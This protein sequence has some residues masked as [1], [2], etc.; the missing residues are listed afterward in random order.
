MKMWWDSDVNMVKVCWRSKC[1]GVK[2]VVQT[3]AGGSMEGSVVMAEASACAS[4]L[5]G[6]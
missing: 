5:E 2:Y 1:G 6:K 3:K 4:E